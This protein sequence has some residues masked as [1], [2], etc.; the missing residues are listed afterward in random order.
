MIGGLRLIF[1]R[2]FPRS[3]IGIHKG[4][5]EGWGIWKIEVAVAMVMAMVRTITIVIIIDQG[6][7]TINQELK[8]NIM[9]DIDKIMIGM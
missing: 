7:S 3:G 8:R 1:H 9:E 4:S 2:V 5:D 6:G